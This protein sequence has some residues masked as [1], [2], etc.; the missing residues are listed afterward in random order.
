MGDYIDL[1]DFFVSICQLSTFIQERLIFVWGVLLVFFDI[2]VLLFNS[3][4]LLVCCCKRLTLKIT[5]THSFFSLR[6]CFE[7]MKLLYTTPLHTSPSLLPSR[8]SPPHLPVARLLTSRGAC[9]PS[10]TIVQTG[11]YFPCHPWAADS[12]DWQRCG[13]RRSLTFCLS[14]WLLWKQNNKDKASFLK[15]W[16]ATRLFLR[17]MTQSQNV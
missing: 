8:L 2:S 5:Q 9:N 1:I 11:R 15:L 7:K 10:S 4:Q 17:L 14:A 12:A 13:S 3:F 16:T 6:S